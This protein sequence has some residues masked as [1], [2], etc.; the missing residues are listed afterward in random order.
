MGDDLIVGRVASEGM[1]FEEFPL[2]VIIASR[3]YTFSWLESD[4]TLIV[5]LELE[6]LNG[7][8]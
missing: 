4:V 2:Q 8:F 3:I 7:L 6:V 5:F 1:L